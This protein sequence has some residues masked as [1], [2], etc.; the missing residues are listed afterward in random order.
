MSDSGTKI[1]PTYWGK[2]GDCGSDW[3]G[4]TVRV[5]ACTGCGKDYCHRCQDAHDCDGMPKEKDD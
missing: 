5:S 4:G 3:D 1:S 2:C